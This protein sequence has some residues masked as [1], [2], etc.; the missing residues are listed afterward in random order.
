MFAPNQQQSEEEL[1][2]AATIMQFRDRI[3]PVHESGQNKEPVGRQSYQDALSSASDVSGSRVPPPQQYTPL[4]SSPLES[5]HQNTLDSPSSPSKA[6]DSMPRPVSCAGIPWNSVKA[7][8]CK[9]CYTKKLRCD[10][11]RP[12]C[13]ACVK[14]NL[15]CEYPLGFATTSPTSSSPISKKQK[16]NDEPAAADSSSFSHIEPFPGTGALLPA[17]EPLNI[18]AILVP[19]LNSVISDLVN[20]EAMKRDPSETATNLEQLKQ[21]MTT[22][23]SDVVAQQQQLQQ[24]QQQEQQQDSSSVA[25]SKRK[26]IDVLAAELEEQSSQKQISLINAVP[27]IVV[28]SHKIH[29]S[30]PLDENRQL[31]SSPTRSFRA[32]IIP[33]TSSPKAVLPVP[34]LASVKPPQ[35]LETPSIRSATLFQPSDAPQH[36]APIIRPPVPPQLTQQEETPIQQA[37]EAITTL[38]DIVIGRLP[39]V[40]EGSFKKL[41]CSNLWIIDPD[42]S[43]K[44]YFCPACKK[45][46][47]TANGLKYHLGQHVD[48]NEFPRGYYWLKR[49]GSGGKEDGESVVNADAGGTSKAYA[50]TVDGCMNEYSS[51]G[52]LKYHIFH[53][54]SVNADEINGDEPS[55]ED[56][57]DLQADENPSPDNPANGSSSSHHQQHQ[58]LTSL[59]HL[60]R[61][62]MVN[63]ETIELS[64]KFKSMKHARN[65][66]KVAAALSNGMTLAD[67]VIERLPK[68]KPGVFKRLSCGKLWIFDPESGEKLYF[69]PICK[70]MYPTANGMKYHLSNSHKDQSEFPAGY[71]WDKKGRSEVAESNN[72]ELPYRCTIG[73]CKNRYSRPAGLNCHI[74]RMHGRGSSEEPPG[75]F[76]GGPVDEGNA[77]DNGRLEEEGE[78]GEGDEDE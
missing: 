22:L 59:D 17:T 76:E 26:R 40:K 70:R 74:T 55:S 16:N 66:A 37:S 60:V 51:L 36:V 45:D 28:P 12:S 49:T 46:Y 38:A 33:P 52:G 56:A 53:G 54:H 30:S 32:P 9:S 20:K 5:A 34:T 1:E 68:L 27:P 48:A 41:S 2:V 39:S 43:D 21:Q 58:P 29:R 4:D 61:V 50:C 18:A 11:E 31:K 35:P 64:K 65:A 19:Q 10:K 7:V 44:V 72:I 13:S 14:R 71:Y 24:Q 25:A 62:A 69:C 77:E 3:D 63:S 75:Y 73:N 15:P 47:K 23:I 8:S 78:D 6:S 42:T 57:D 67:L